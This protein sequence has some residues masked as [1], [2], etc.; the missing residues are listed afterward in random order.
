MLVRKLIEEKVIKG[1]QIIVG[2]GEC[3]FKAGEKPAFLYYLK[4]G[5]V[6]LTGTLKDELSVQD[7]FECKLI[8]L[9]E[10]MLDAHTTTAEVL[11]PSELI[12]I[13]RNTFQELLHRN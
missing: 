10:L 8:G 5:H 2:P 9:P 12:K 1:K 6:R 4:N 13:D 3:L 7:I 11:A